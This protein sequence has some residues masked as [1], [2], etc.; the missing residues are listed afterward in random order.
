MTLFLV[1]SQR[2]VPGCVTWMCL[3]GPLNTARNPCHSNLT[4]S[5]VPQVLGEALSL[6]RIPCMELTEFA[7]GAAQSGLLSLKETTELFLYFTAYNKPT[8]TYPTK[9]RAGLRKQICHR[10]VRR[11]ALSMKNLCRVASYLQTY[12]LL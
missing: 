6:I 12:I 4:R 1:V 3:P 11:T 10:C 7:N 8:V 5:F 9:H 2:S